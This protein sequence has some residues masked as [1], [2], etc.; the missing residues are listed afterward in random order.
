IASDRGMF[1]ER[2]GQAER[3][4]FRDWGVKTFEDVPFHVIDPNDG[5]IPNVILLHSEN[6]IIPRTMPKQVVLPCHT[7]ARRIHFLSGVSGWGYPASERGTTSLIVRIKYADGESEDHELKNGVHFA[8]YIR[9]V[10]VPE[11][12]Y[13]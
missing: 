5:R 7:A 11:S 12:K 13:A 6:G 8:D 4:I 2:D 3:L 10:D 1:F 9:R